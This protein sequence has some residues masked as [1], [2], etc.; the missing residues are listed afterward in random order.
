MVIISS[1]YSVNVTLNSM[2]FLSQAMSIN[3][4]NGQFFCAYDT[5]TEP[6]VS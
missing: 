3:E 2:L 4:I 6:P 1:I 5:F